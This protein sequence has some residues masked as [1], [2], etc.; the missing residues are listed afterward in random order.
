[1]YVICANGD[2]SQ[3][4]ADWMTSRDVDAYSVTG[5]TDT[6][7]RG[8]RPVAAGTHEHAAHTPAA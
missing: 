1:M 3:T 7:A 2:R 4:A 8:G 5:G 6:C